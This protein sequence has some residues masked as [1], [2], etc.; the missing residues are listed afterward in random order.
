MQ[1]PA[2]KTEHPYHFWLPEGTNMRSIEASALMLGLALTGCGA[3]PSSQAI[4]G[5]D[6]GGTSEDPGEVLDGG[7]GS[8]DSKDE[9]GTNT[10]TNPPDGQDPKDLEEC[11]A[12]VA[13]I[14]DFKD[15]HPD[16]ERFSGGLQPGLVQPELGADDKPIYAAS[17]ATANSAG[18]ASFADWYRD[19]PNVNQTIE[20]EI[21]L[22]EQAQG[23]YVYDNQDFFPADEKGFGNQNRGHNYHFT[24][25]VH[26]Q[27]VYRG[28]ER[29]TFTGDD[30]L[31]LFINQQLA[32][33]LGGVHGPSSQTVDLD[34]RAAEL[35]ITPGQSYQMDIFHAERHTTQ[36][37]FRIETSI[38]CFKPVDLI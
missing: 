27:F 20:V 7:S 5:S 3:D 13:K 33:D 16:F 6:A 31:W 11:G 17:G 12:L 28:G 2:A 18:A 19:A 9:P 24:T 10:G 14:R 32:I 29:F 25:E 37:T 23:L 30:D 4:Q 34:A 21:K 8:P 35:G 22:T 38:D 26:T 15:D 36:S 1:L